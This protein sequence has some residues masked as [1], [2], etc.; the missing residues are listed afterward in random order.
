LKTKMLSV[1]LVLLA[2]GFIAVTS[3]AAPSCCDP[4]NGSTTGATIAPGQVS[5][6]VVAPFPQQRVVEPQAIPAVNRGAGSNWAGQIPQTRYAAERPVGLPRAPAAPSCCASPNNNGPAR[7]ITPPAQAQF[8]G[9]GCCGGAAGRGSCSSVQPLPRTNQSALTR[10][11]AGQQ[12]APAGQP[13]CCQP[14]GV[15]IQAGRSSAQFQG[16]AEQ[17]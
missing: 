8:R 11:N 1:A 14:A 5:G 10:P 17:W 13:S 3:Y 12:I 15:N 7:G 4:K 2:V 9:C 16:F 6:P